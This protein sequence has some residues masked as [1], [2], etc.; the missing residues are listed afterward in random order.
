MAQQKLYIA[1]ETV[2]TWRNTGGTNTWNPQSSN[3]SG[4]GRLGAYNDFG[5]AAHAAEYW[6]RC[7]LKPGGTRVIGEIVQV[8]LATGNGTQYDLDET[9]D[10]ALST[11]ASIANVGRIGEIRITKDSAT[12]MSASGRIWILARYAAPLIWNSTANSLSSTGSDYGFDLIPVP[13]A[14]QASA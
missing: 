6:W 5:T 13:P 14:L 12:T 11:L 1:P 4:A 3:T 8:G 7:W 2:I 10:G 9:G